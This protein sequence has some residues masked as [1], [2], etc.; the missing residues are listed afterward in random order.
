MSETAR[1]TAATLLAPAVLAELERLQLVTHRRLA[2]RFSGEHRSPAFG[3]SVDFADYRDYHPGDDFRR[4]DYPL[5]ARTGNLFIRLF[6]AEEDVTVRLIVDRSASMGMYGKLL[7]A[8]RLAAAIGFV[9]LIRRDTVFVHP[10]PGDLPPRRFAGRHATGA[11][12]EHLA[13]LDAV[14]ATALAARSRDIAAR[15]TRSGVTV[16]ISDLLSEDWPTAVDRF[17]AAGGDTTVIHV[18]A[19]E[20]LEPDLHGDLEIV[21]VESGATVPASLSPAMLAEYRRNV[22]QWLTSVA[23]HCRRRG[24]TYVR[25]LADTPAHEVLV[26]AWLENGVLR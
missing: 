24:A 21:D 16:L 7:Q 2:G 6:E 23:A 20:E 13:E 14:G 26:R 12:F 18:V 25:V 9:A 5:Y 8:Q 4:I 19:G 3:A 1:P 10:E 15:S 11:L 22:D 17:S